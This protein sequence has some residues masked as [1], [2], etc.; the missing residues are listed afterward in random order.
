MKILYFLCCFILTYSRIKRNSYR[1][2]QGDEDE[3]MIG[4]KREPSYNKEDE[5]EKNKVQERRREDNKGSVISSPID[6]DLGE[7]KE[8]V[9][10]SKIMDMRKDYEPDKMDK[11][12]EEIL[13]LK[14][15]PI[16]DTSTDLITSSIESSKD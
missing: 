7:T 9:K 8:I 12:Y 6:L 4:K 2:G 1:K 14:Q 15:L 16:T 10:T 11:N 5:A 13:K 3:K